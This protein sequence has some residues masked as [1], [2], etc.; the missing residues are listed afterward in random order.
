L[1][2]FALG[3]ESSEATDGGLLVFD[4]AGAIADSSVTSDAV[5]PAP[6]GAA[7]GLDASTKPDAPSPH[8]VPPFGG[9]SGGSGGKAPVAGTVQQA[10]VVTFRLIVPASYSASRPTPLLVVYS[11]TE[12]GAQMTSN[13][14]TIGPQTGMD[15]FV[16]AVLDGVQYNGDGGAG[17][18][19]LDA[20]RAA[21][22]IDNDRT[23]LLGESAGTTAAFGLG[24]HL[25]QSYF[26]AY[27][28]N[29]VNAVDAPA[30]NASALGFAP[31]GQ[32]GPGGQVAIAQKIAAS[33]V[34]AGYR[35][36]NPAPYNGP[37]ANQH[38]SPEQ[39]VAA[40]S[41]FP[42]KSRR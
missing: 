31:N 15:G 39:F 36:P 16:C 26:A 37:G 38:G 19:V 18:L 6:D 10:G 7:T 41:W 28:A 2:A 21:Y 22:N 24:F 29:D 20:V 40:L 1:C 25:R 34:A 30:E 4:D 23:Y 17:A 42:G 5:P 12:G 8:G 27:W 11:G 3:C 13:L 32:V 33:M 35:V 14:I 9:A